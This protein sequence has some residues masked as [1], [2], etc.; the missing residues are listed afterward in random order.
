M[1]INDLQESAEYMSLV[2]QLESKVQELEAARREI[3]R[4]NKNI[5][6]VQNEFFS[7]RKQSDVVSNFELLYLNICIVIIN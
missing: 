5:L 6:S 7:V 1:S 4:L 3:E 2:N